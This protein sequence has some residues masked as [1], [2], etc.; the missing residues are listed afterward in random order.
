[1]E[2]IGLTMGDHC[3]VFH[4]SSHLVAIFESSSRGIDDR[5]VKVQGALPAPID[6]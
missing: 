1:M 3:K 4:L 5:R 2:P 6:R